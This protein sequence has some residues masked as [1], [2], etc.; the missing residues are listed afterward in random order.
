M[1]SDPA[2][3]G[4]K[5]NKPTRDMLGLTEK[6][7]KHSVA[8]LIAL[9]AFVGAS[10]AFLQVDARARSASADRDSRALTLESMGRGGAGIQRYVYERDQ[11][12]NYRSL[13]TLWSLEKRLAQ[14]K[15]ALSAAEDNELAA[16]RLWQVLE[17]LRSQ[18][19]LLSPPYYDESSARIDVFQFGV[20]YLVLPSTETAERQAAKHAEAEAWG[21]KANNYVIC[22]TVLAVCLFL[23]GLAVTIGG[24]LKYLFVVLGSL[25]A[26]G[27]LLAVVATLWLP[28]PRISDES[29]QQYARGVGDL[30]YALQL[31]SSSQYAEVPPRA[32]QAAASLTRAIASRGDYGAAFQAR[33]D[34]HL[35]K[36][37]SLIFS[38][39]DPAEI[40]AELDLAI[41]DLLQAINLGR[42]DRHSYWNLGW[43]YFLARR[44]SE[45]MTVMQRA[46]ELAPN[47][48]FG[49][50]LNM[51][52]NLL[53][54]GKR[55]E[56]MKELE[57]S[58]TWAAEH[59]LASDPYY[60][61]Q[62][63]L[64]LHRLKRAQPIDGMEEIEKRLKEAFVSIIYRETSSVTPTGARVGAFEFTQPVLNGQGEVVKGEP[65]TR[66]PRGTDRVALAFEYAGMSKGLLIVQKVLRDGQEQ[67]ELTTSERW[68]LADAGRAE[69]VLRS[70]VEHTLAG[71]FPGVYTVEWYVEGELVQS[72]SFEVE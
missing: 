68:S 19:Q 62:M 30:Y 34:V 43:T 45:S 15:A 60:F 39:G 66:F 55:D 11:L 4:K 22:I 72:G 54:Q 28:V 32:D 31:H 42:A 50:G 41:A 71:L 47:M 3:D 23:Y 33:G 9:V 1:S 20:D 61:R 69:L 38:R 12:L 37:E 17:T 57:R 56:A 7:F 59:S 16:E 52:L 40:K 35:I 48:R 14:D 8:L 18:S 64:N 49:L 70:P 25:I 24:R 5:E 13:V 6:Q 44:Y 65:T 2:V 58:L 21:N 29:I 63:I 36:A 53:G 10:V 46:V 51:A 67:P 27:I 26:E